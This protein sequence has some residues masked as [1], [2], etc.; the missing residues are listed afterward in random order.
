M[1]DLHIVHLLTLREYPEALLASSIIEDANRPVHRAAF[2]LGY[3]ASPQYFLDAQELILIVAVQI[4][5]LPFLVQQAI[6]GFEEIISIFQ[7]SSA[8]TDRHPG[9]YEERHGPMERGDFHGIQGR[10]PPFSL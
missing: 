3:F 10:V 7:F 9:E 1:D 8:H 4:D 2:D 5:G 6:P